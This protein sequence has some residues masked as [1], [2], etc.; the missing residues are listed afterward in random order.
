MIGLTINRRD[1]VGARP[2]HR[3]GLIESALAPLAA[4]DA[5]V[6]AV[7]DRL[8]HLRNDLAVVVSAEALFT[9]ADIKSLTPTAAVASVNVAASRLV[10]EAVRD[11]VS[12]SGR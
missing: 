7:W 1:A 2:A 4:R 11:L 3:I 10:D 6:D 9:L 5:D 12:G 8:R